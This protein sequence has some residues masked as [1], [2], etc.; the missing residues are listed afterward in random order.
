VGSVQNCNGVTTANTAN[1]TCLP[2]LQKLGG[3]RDNKFLV[4]HL[5][6]DFWESCLTSASA[7][8]AH[9]PWGHWPPPY[10]GYS[11]RKLIGWVIKNLYWVTLNLT[12]AHW[13]L[14]GFARNIIR[15]PVTNIVLFCWHHH[16]HHHHHQPINVQVTGHNPPCG[17]SVDW[18]VLTT[19]NAAG[20][21]G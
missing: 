8:R 4:T 17:P 9:W 19:A 15:S 21:N 3:A 7:S 5:M 10:L 16:H 13:L 14:D 1:I 12:S 2:R 20:S 18:W 11:H 6:T